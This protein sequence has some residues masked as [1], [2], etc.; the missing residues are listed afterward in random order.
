M[1]EFAKR[2]DAFRNGRPD[3]Y[4]VAEFLAPFAFEH[5]PELLRDDMPAKNRPEGRPAIE[6]YWLVH[7][8]ELIRQQRPGYT[9]KAAIKL[10]ANGE[11]P[12]RVLMTDAGTGERRPGRIQ[13]GL[14]KGQKPRSLE[15][16]YYEHLR[17]WEKL[18]EEQSIEIPTT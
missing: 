5:F 11:A 17:V 16:R 1:V 8:V 14:W 2:I 4:A 10:L 9:V 3:W 7:D 18:A 12:H 6:W 13:S 15:Q